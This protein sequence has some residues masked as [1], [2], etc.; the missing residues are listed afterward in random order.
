MIRHIVLIKFKSGVSDEK[1]DQLLLQM[2]KTKDSF[3]KMRSF[4]WGKNCT[5]EPYNSGYSHCFEMEFDNEN[6]IE[7]YLK[8]EAQERATDEFIPYLEDG[9]NSVIIFDYKI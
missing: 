4:S 1:I 5:K 2:S 7:H 9:L 8:S 6:D 3:P